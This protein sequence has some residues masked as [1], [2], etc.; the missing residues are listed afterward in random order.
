MGVTVMLAGI[1]F[2]REYG[3]PSLDPLETIPLSLKICSPLIGLRSS[4]TRSPG[5][6]LSHGDDEIDE[7]GG[8]DVGLEGLPKGGLSPV[9]FPCDF[10]T[11][12]SFEGKACPPPIC[13]R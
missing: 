8:G 12:L 5:V 11:H 10:Y 4:I 13:L 6:S 7:S 1:E 3:P 9:A 2:P